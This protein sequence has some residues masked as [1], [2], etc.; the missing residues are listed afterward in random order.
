[1]LDV[2]TSDW[3]RLTKELNLS[4]L[5]DILRNDKNKPPT[6]LLLKYLDVSETV[7]ISVNVCFQTVDKS[8]QGKTR[9]YKVD[10]MV[11]ITPLQ[12]FTRH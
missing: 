10:S 3:K 12:G 4:S 9:V 5:I 7:A 2:R 6:L 8:K 1:M 11:M